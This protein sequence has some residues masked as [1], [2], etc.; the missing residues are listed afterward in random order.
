MGEESETSIFISSRLH[1]TSNARFTSFRSPG[2]VVRDLKP[3][4]EYSL[5]AEKKGR[6]KNQVVN[7]MSRD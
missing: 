6:T 3:E 7:L 5:C 1:Q 2:V 4:E